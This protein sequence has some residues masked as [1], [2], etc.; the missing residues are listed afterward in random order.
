MIRRYGSLLTRGQVLIIDAI[1]AGSRR[2]PHPPCCTRAHICGGPLLWTGALRDGKYT[3]SSGLLPLPVAIILIWIGYIVVVIVQLEKAVAASH[4]YKYEQV[5]QP[6]TNSQQEV[7][8]VLLTVFAQAHTPITAMILARLAVSALS[9]A[10]EYSF[11]TPCP[12]VLNLTFTATAPKTWLELFFLA[13]GDWKSPLGIARALW[14]SYRRKTPMSSTFALLG[15]TILLSIPLPLLLS[16]AYPYKVEV[17]VASYIWNNI[18]FDVNDQLAVGLTAWRIT[19]FGDPSNFL[20][21]AFYVSD[22]GSIEGSPVVF[23]TETPQLAGPRSVVWLNGSCSVMQNDSTPDLPS[24]GI[25]PDFDTWCTAHALN[26]SSVEQAVY[27]EGPVSFA[28][29]WCSD[30]NQ[31]SW[32][33]SPNHFPSTTSVVAWLELNATGSHAHTEGFIN[34]T[35]SFDTG[36]AT[37]ISSDPFSILD[38]NVSGFYYDGTFSDFMADHTPITVDRNRFWPPVYAAFASLAQDHASDNLTITRLFPMEPPGM[39]DM[40]ASLINGVF[41]MHAA[42]GIAALGTPPITRTTPVRNRN[43][44]F[45]VAAV[46]VLALWLLLLLICFWRLFSRAFGSSLNAY[47]A[48][49]LLVGTLWFILLDLAPL[50]YTSSL[51]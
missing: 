16:R 37:L 18:Q 31:S 46:V 22:T 36:S 25:T 47:V 9:S 8:T 15:A 42:A 27:E 14:T 50:T 51:V 41:R 44:G 24:S 23:S 45:F 19:N 40:A 12:S 11:T 39:H 29:H 10:C 33:P 34:C 26:G 28:M 7:L 6:F 20:P 13:E 30:F 4:S 32:D 21:G 43:T 5:I 1:R 2:D 38:R 48:A 3:H 35:H 17:E 49:R